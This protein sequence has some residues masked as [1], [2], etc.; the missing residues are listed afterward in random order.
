MWTRVLRIPATSRFAA[1][2]LVVAAWAVLWVALAIAVV[3]S[4]RDVAKLGGTVSQTGTAVSQVGGLINDIPLIPDNVSSASSSVQAAG[5]SAQANGAQGEDAANRLGIYL[6]IAIALIPS[7][8]ILGLYL[9]VRIARVRERRVAQRALALHGHDPQYQ[10]FLAR[11][12]LEK[13]QYEDIM[14]VSAHPW[15]DLNHGRFAALASAELHRLEIYQR[16]PER[17]TQAV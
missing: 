7:V 13:L 9:P 11:R 2:D 1:P 16:L 5:A 3:Q 17:A 4:T 10:E 15:D 14:A 6:G 12:A 8:P